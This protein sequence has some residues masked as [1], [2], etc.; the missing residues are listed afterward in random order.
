MTSSIKM[1]PEDLVFDAEEYPITFG[2]LDAIKKYHKSLQKAKE[3]RE[4]AISKATR[5]YTEEVAILVEQL[6]ASLK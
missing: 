3:K 5:E 2:T 1:G 4:V 6:K